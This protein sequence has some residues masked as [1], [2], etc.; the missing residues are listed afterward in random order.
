MARADDDEALRRRARPRPPPPTS[1]ASM[2]AQSES[3][4][5]SRAPR[6]SKMK[7]A[8]LMAV[9]DDAD[10]DAN[11]QSKS[12][13]VKVDPQDPEPWAPPISI[14]REPSGSRFSI[15]DEQTQA[16]AQ[17]Q[18]Q[19][20]SQASSLFH[21]EM[22]PIIQ[23]FSEERRANGESKSGAPVANGDASPP[24]TRSMYDFYFPSGRA[25]TNGAGG[26]RSLKRKR[27]GA[28]RADEL[29]AAE[30]DLLRFGV[31]AAK[32]VPQGLVDRVDVHMSRAV[33][34]KVVGNHVA[35]W[36]S[37][38]GFAP[39][40]RQEI[41]TLLAAYYPCNYPTLLDEVL[42]GFLFKRPEFMELLL[43]PM[44]EKM[45]KAGESVST[46]KYPVADA[47]VRMCAMTAVR[48]SPQAVARHD[49]ACRSLLRC[50]V[51]NN[52]DRFVLSPWIVACAIESSDSVLR[53]LWRALLP[54]YTMAEPDEDD[55][56]W[57]IQDPGQQIVELLAEEGKLRACRMTCGFV[58]LLVSDDDMKKQLVDSQSYLVPD[59]LE[60]AFTYA[61]TS[62][63]ASL[64]V[65]WLKRRRKQHSDGGSFTDFVDFLVRF[66]SKLS[67]KKPEWFVK[68]VLSFVLSPQCQVEE[69]EPALRAI[70]RGYMPFV[71]GAL[72]D[73]S[74][75]QKSRQNGS[76][77]S[78]TDTTGTLD[79]VGSQ[80]VLEARSKM[81]LLV[82]LL[83]TASARSSTL[84]VGVWS[85]VWSDKRTTPSWSHVHALIGVAIQDSVEDRSE[86]GQKLLS[87]T[88]RVCRSYYYRLSR[89]IGND[90]TRDEVAVK[91]SE[92]LNLL[93]PSTRPVGHILLQEV[94]GALADFGHEHS[95][96]ACTI[97]GNA[98]SLQLGKCGG[99]G[100]GT[101]VKRV[102]VQKSLVEYDRSPPNAANEASSLNLS[103]SAHLLTTLKSL[104]GTKN[105]TGDFIR[106]VLS[107]GR[108]VR[109]LA[110]LLN[111]GRRR[112]RQ[113]VLLDVMNVVVVSNASAKLNWD[114]T[115]RYV[116]QELLY[117]AYTGPPSSARKAIAL[118]R[119]IFRNSTNGVRALLWVILQQCTKL[120]CGR[121]EKPSGDSPFPTPDNYQGRADSLA[122]L[123]KAMV[124][125]VP[126]ITVREVLSF[127]EQK[128]SSCSVGKTRMNLF[129][130]LLLR[131]LVVCELQC[132]VLLP[133][134][135]LA[136]CPLAP[137][138][139]DQIRL[140]QLQL[141]K[142]LCSRLV[143]IR[144]RPAAF[145]HADPDADWKR[146]E[147]LICNERL[148]SD[149]RSM[150]KVAPLNGVYA[151]V[152]RTT[153][154][155]ASEV[156]AQ[157]ILVFTHQLKQ[158]SLI[159]E[160]EGARRE[161]KKG[162]TK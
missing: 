120:C 70:L 135:Q 109:L 17:A 113:E 9:V 25:E 117:C 150:V 34:V 35:N 76:A 116:V 69:Q 162:R 46:T 18:A 96:D 37:R 23:S 47:L 6:S 144:H 39:G 63:S 136:V 71:F 141:L 139:S 2:Y 125:T 151:K 29:A 91:F 89:H 24:A 33:L 108:L 140:I 7:M 103:T 99:G 79:V 55:L 83:I 115:R 82:G 8:S 105:T 131:K 86:F 30:V 114:W 44:L 126:A 41:T 123:V 22:P 36:C 13:R 60:R 160:E 54:R 21:S 15:A 43:P 48:T 110:G 78:A 132:G 3:S 67:V 124:I 81:E 80:A 118:L 94:L 145:E 11:S 98:V 158:Q 27:R 100:L 88:T 112:R 153:C 5:S 102:V 50:L 14:S 12:K 127:V 128:L 148:Q 19:A 64:M 40:F 66:N 146:Y 161:L 85:E 143:A 142:A 56:D 84:F 122:E 51:E 138:D 73:Q 129:L 149:L 156:L 10:V 68:H 106:R 65:E 49:L 59:C 104:A 95:A 147:S 121:E 157:G 77:D 111:A 152:E 38:S 53:T 20:Q 1:I 154:S 28:R 93:L 75:E 57:R 4:S 31:D 155:R 87:L 134:V 58:E 101:S 61:G 72:D 32:L 137:S 62:W 16:Q 133:V 119:N 107:S 159:D 42:A 52:E 74:L 130:L 45:S 97:F 90:N 26:N 92:A